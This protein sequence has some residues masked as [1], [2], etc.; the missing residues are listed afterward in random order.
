MRIPANASNNSRQRAQRMLAR[1]R[2][3]PVCLVS[4][5]LVLLLT[6]VVLGYFGVLDV[7]SALN[8]PGR[9]TGAALIVAA[10]ITFLGAVGALD[11]WVWHSFPYSGPVALFG[12]FVALL[13]N[14]L[15][16]V[17]I[18]KDG[19]SKFY[20][21]VFCA[22]TVGSAGA[23]FAVWRTS[24]VIPAP[25]RVAAAL[26]VTSVIAVGNFGY[27]NLYMPSQREAEPVIKLATGAPVTSRDH[28]AFSVPIDITMENHSD[29]AFYILGDIFHAMAQRVPLSPKDRL[30]QQWRTDSEQWKDFEGANPLSRREIHQPGELVE[31][32]P[33]MPY[34]RWIDPGDTFS[35]RVVLQLPMGTPYDEVTFYASASLAR[36]DRMAVEDLNFKGYSWQ[37]SA[38]VPSWVSGNKEWDALVFRGKIDE[39]NAIDEHTR[40]RRTLSVYWRFGT[41]GADILEAITSPHGPDASSTETQTRYG[42]RDV[43]TGPVERTLWDI[44]SRR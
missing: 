44:K 31:A 37:G 43:E 20:L 28:K 13:S 27:Q 39:N 35:A 10:I 42:I 3:S 2:R 16:L 6:T 21:A 32:Q 40:D 24:V 1:N 9:V 17:G 11:H 18:L 34:A 14:V 33:W 25:K 7:G 19:D 4:I 41:H 8:F 12:A 23:V 30:R 22:L 36:K 26:I 15:L 5:L 38:H 29:V